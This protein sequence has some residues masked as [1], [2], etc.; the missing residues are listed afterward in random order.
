M[1]PQ[2]RILSA[3]A[4]VLGI[5]AVFVGVFKWDSSIPWWANILT[6]LIAY[7]VTLGGVAL[8]TGK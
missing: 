4:V 8:V 7:I 2:A 3:F 5:A 6:V 1:D